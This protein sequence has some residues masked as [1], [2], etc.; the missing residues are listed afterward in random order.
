MTSG[1]QQAASPPRPDWPGNCAAVGGQ[2]A[3]GPAPPYVSMKAASERRLPSSVNG[4]IWS[5][6]QKPQP[7]P[8]CES[9]GT[10]R[11]CHMAVPLDNSAFAERDISASFLWHEPLFAFVL[12]LSLRMFGLFLK[13]FFFN[14]RNDPRELWVLHWWCWLVPTFVRDTRAHGGHLLRRPCGHERRAA[15]VTGL[16]DAQ[17]QEVAKL[18]KLELCLFKLLIVGMTS[19]IFPLE[20]SPGLSWS[21]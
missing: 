13:V 17:G 21:V 11:T 18:P 9:S 8:T 3:Q 4:K 12:H 5:G 2:T 20:S 16:P 7:L 15:Q 19:L 14:A 6:C 1:E 10:R